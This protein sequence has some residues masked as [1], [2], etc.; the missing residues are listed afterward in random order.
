MN[1]IEMRAVCRDD[2][3]EIYKLCQILKEE[4]ARMSFTDVESESDINTWLDD[5]NNYLYGAFDQS[6][7]LAGLLRAKRGVNN[8]SHSVYLA[9]AVNP[10]YRKRNIA[11]ELTS[12]ALEQLKEKGVKIARTYIY[13]W[14]KASIATIEKC[15]FIFGGSVV[16]HE[17][18]PVTETYIDDLI[19]HKIL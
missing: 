10:E 7:K 2:V 1:E 13:S 9:A 8:K 11:N 19:Y 6:G 4:N 5:P 14:N 17:Y 15:G 12:F 16:M 18:D 3:G